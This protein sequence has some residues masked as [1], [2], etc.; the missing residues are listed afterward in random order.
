MF[1]EKFLDESMAYSSAFF[2]HDDMSL[3]DAQTEKMDR[4]CRKLSLQPEDHVL[5]IGCGWGSQA[6]H[7]AR[8]Y[9][10]RVTAITLS[11]SQR[12]YAS[13][14]VAE[15]GLSGRIHIHLTDYRHVR[16]K[17]DKIVSIEMLEAVG[18]KFLP[19]YF[20]ECDRLLKPGGLMA[21][22]SILGA[23]RRYRH[24]RKNSDWIRK[25]IF[26]GS[27]LPTVS[28][29]AKAKP[30][31]LDLD[32]YHFESFGLHYARTLLLWLQRFQSEWPHIEALGFDALFSRKWSYYLAFCAAAFAERHI[33]VAQ[34]VWGRTNCRSYSFERGN[35]AHMAAAG[36]PEARK[37]TFA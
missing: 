17:Y 25:H 12:E 10:C 16:G 36:K 8:R 2:L 22:Q 29:L 35:G 6:I 37:S 33:N 19:R 15:A 18:E 24:Y 13:R 31:H 1:Y 32:L 11:P 34:F 27:H 21:V 14:M 7:M 4:I 3:G 30:D 23:E 20:S 26:P 9:G 5:E 28:S